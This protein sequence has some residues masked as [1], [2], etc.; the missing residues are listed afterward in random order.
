MLECRKY[1]EFFRCDL[2]YLWENKAVRIISVFV[3]MKKKAT[4]RQLPEVVVH[5]YELQR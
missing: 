5:L 4:F 2:S 1:V 3:S